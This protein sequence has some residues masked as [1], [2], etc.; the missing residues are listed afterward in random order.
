MLSRFACRLS[1]GM[2]CVCVCV[3]GLMGVGFLC[4]PIIETAYELPEFGRVSIVCSMPSSR[5]SSRFFHLSVCSCL[6][7]FIISLFKYHDPSED[8]WCNPLFVYLGPCFDFLFDV[9]IETQVKVSPSRY[10]VA[11]VIIVL[12]CTARSMLLLSMVCE[13][14]CCVKS[15]PRESVFCVASQAGS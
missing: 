7:P 11:C 8:I 14:S 4:L 12:Q 10:L 9:P 5:F 3:S 2:F 6:I 13:R 15:E 1:V